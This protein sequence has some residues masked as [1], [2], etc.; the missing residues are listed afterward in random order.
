[1]KFSKYKFEADLYGSLKH[2][3]ELGPVA[4]EVRP[5]PVH[6]APVLQ[7]VVLGGHHRGDGGGDACDGYDAGDAAA[8]FPPVFLDVTASPSS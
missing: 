2:V 8:D 3:A 5:H 6:H 7:Q 4:E 1:M